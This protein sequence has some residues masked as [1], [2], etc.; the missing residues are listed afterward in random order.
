M[1]HMT[2]MRILEDVYKK[3]T[4]LLF[5]SDVIVITPRDLD[6]HVALSYFTLTHILLTVQSLYRT[7]SAINVNNKMLL[8]YHS[9]MIACVRA[10]WLQVHP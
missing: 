4:H 9:D 3:S 10:Q 5:W 6:Q 7:S 2:G 8:Q 1:C